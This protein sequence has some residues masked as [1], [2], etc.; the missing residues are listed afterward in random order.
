MQVARNNTVQRIIRC[1]QIMG[2]KE[3]ESLS[4]AQILYP[5]MQTA[6]IFY[7]KADICQLG[8]DQRKVNV[9][10]REVGPTLGLW[11]PVVVS[12]HMLMGLGEPAADTTDAVERAISMKMSKS[13]PDSAIFMTDTKEEIT[14]KLKKAY[15]PER[16]VKENPVLEYYKYI[17]FE[18]FSSITIE[19]PAKFGGPLVFN[20]YV[21]FEKEFAEGKMH[22]L[23]VKNT[24][25]SLI[26]S[27]LEPVR[28][29][30]QENPEAKRLKELVESYDV[31][32]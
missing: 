7:L 30:F 6:D 14:R 21:Q 11:K 5:C 4:A 13:N 1:S 20:S 24:A 22:P 29:H 8:M 15:C 10:A 26:N 12:H 23:D 32:R 16:Q 27:L 3:S 2:R 25:A 17:L 31:T 9:L 18:K 19:R 28:R